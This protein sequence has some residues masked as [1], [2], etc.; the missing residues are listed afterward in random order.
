[1]KTYWLNPCEGRWCPCV[2]CTDTA[3]PVVLAELFPELDQYTVVVTDYNGKWLVREGQP[4]KLPHIAELQTGHLI[5]LVKDVSDSASCGTYAAE[6]GG[7]KIATN[8]MYFRTEVTLELIRRSMVT[9]PGGEATQWVADTFDPTCRDI[10]G[11]GAPYVNWLAHVVQSGKE[12]DLPGGSSAAKFLQQGVT[13]EPD[14]WKW[15]YAFPRKRKEVVVNLCGG[16]AE[17]PCGERFPVGKIPGDGLFRRREDGQ[18]DILLRRGSRE[19][20]DAGWMWALVDK[21]GNGVVAAL[22]PLDNYS[23]IG[24]NFFPYTPISARVQTAWKKAREV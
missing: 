21:G 19:I 6:F 20:G 23:G 22:D 14:Q 17:L 15:L 8:Q 5:R 24:G 2:P 13:G 1:M 10:W 9:F 16:W 3:V 4:W 11:G 18:Y 7:V 12:Q